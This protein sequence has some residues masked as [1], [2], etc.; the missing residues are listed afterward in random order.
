MQSLFEDSPRDEHIFRIQTTTGNVAF[1]GVRDYASMI[2]DGCMLPSLMMDH[3]GLSDGAT[4]EITLINATRSLPLLVPLPVAAEFKLQVTSAEQYDR[5]H[6]LS[7]RQQIGMQNAMERAIDENFPVVRL[8]DVIPVHF[9]GHTFQMQVMGLKKAAQSQ[10]D[11]EA[12]I[13]RAMRES[14]KRG[15]DDVAQTEVTDHGELIRVRLPAWM[16]FERR[17]IFE[18]PQDWIP[19]KP[20]DDALWDAERKMY[21]PEGWQW[22]EEQ[23][24][25]IKPPAPEI[26]D[27]QRART[28]A[29][30]KP[31][32]WGAG[33]QLGGGS[34]SSAAEA[35][36]AERKPLTAAELR[37]RR[38]RAMEARAASGGYSAE[39]VP[40]A[41]ADA[42]VS[43]AVDGPGCPGEA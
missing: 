5:I 37:D 36:D 32:D 12:Q 18:A 4:I 14:M 10:E 40:K 42:G 41:P 3:L 28:D 33:Q 39:Q 19:P 11:E 7:P 22:D 25:Y 27:L 9:E 20:F 21:Y 13:Q 8:G 16:S 26:P 2:D 15:D 31:A 38:L 30:K 1:A 17:L 6:A 35:A 24:T 34:S 29:E 23:Q 43:K